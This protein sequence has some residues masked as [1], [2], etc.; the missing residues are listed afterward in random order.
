MH[1]RQKKAVELETFSWGVI[2]KFWTDIISFAETFLSVSKSQ[3]AEDRRSKIARLTHLL[4]VKRT[5]G[6]NSRT[7]RSS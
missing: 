4:A 7:F 6:I 1:L 5:F 3:T 2:P